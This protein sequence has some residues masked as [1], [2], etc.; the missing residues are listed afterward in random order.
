MW[1]SCVSGPEAKRG[2]N[3]HHSVSCGGIVEPN[4]A[5]PMIPHQLSH[6]PHHFPISLK[7]IPKSITSQKGYKK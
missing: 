5:F 6:A 3:V 7:K 1:F 2:R 4:K